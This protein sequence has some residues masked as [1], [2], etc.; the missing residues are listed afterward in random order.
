MAMH[1]SKK[2]YFSGLLEMWL[3][4]FFVMSVVGVLIFQFLGTPWAAGWAIICGVV[5]GKW[6]EYELNDHDQA[7]P[8]Q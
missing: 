2:V 7:D 5:V 3:L 1:W 8:H 4:V 6:V